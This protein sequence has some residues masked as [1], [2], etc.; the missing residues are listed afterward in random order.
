M[1]IKTILFISIAWPDKGNR[2]LYKDLMDEFRDHGHKVFVVCSDEKLLAKSHYEEE[3]GINVLRV[4]TLK[5]TKTGILDKA[6][7]LTTLGYRLKKQINKHF[8]NNQFDLII[9]PTPPITLSRFL[10]NIKRKYNAKLYL[11]LKDIWPYGFR[12][13]GVIKENGLAWKYF[14]SH[15]KRIY[16]ISDYIG[17]MSE[18]NVSFVKEN[19]P[20]VENKIEVN[21]NSVK[22]TAQEK[23]DREF[24]KNKYDI[25]T[26]SILFLFSGN[27]GLGH[28]LEFLVKVIKELEHYTKSFF[29]IGGSGTHYE[30]VKSQLSKNKNVFVYKYLPKKDFNKILTSSD[31]GLILLSDKYNYPQFPSRLLGYLNAKIPVLCA[32]NKNTDIGEVV[33]KNKVGISSIH[34]D[35]E[36][37]KDAV[38]KLSENKNIRKTMGENGFKLLQKEYTVITSYNIIMK[39]FKTNC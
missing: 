10:K 23:P 15:E 4:K 12:D 6:L 18:Q 33:E 2:N 39:H 9:F 37:F 5:L 8:Q 26:D 7:A 30:Y 32:I 1:K 28:G 31:V 21:P 3:D 19:Y 38:Y 36:S 27:L 14:K 25:P 29:L 22:I 13:L 20:W 17:C 16:K 11:L 24:L 35:I 34:G